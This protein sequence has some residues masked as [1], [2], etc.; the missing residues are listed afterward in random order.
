MLLIHVST[1]LKGHMQNILLDPARLADQ[2]I[3]SDTSAMSQAVKILP[4]LIIIT[5][6]KKIH[7]LELGVEVPILCRRK[8]QFF[9]GIILRGNTKSQSVILY[10]ALD[11]SRLLLSRYRFSDVQGM[12]KILE[13]TVK[14]THFFINS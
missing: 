10:L 12:G 2:N 7:V 13:T 3:S 11:V 5:H 9:I 8:D 6:R 14:D 4:Y 1:L